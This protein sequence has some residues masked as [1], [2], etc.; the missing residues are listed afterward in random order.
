MQRT[1]DHKPEEVLA[2]GLQRIRGLGSFYRIALIVS[3]VLGVI[4]VIA[5]IVGPISSGWGERQP[6]TYVAVTFGFLMSTLGAAPCVSVG[7]RLVRSHWRRP[8][9]RLAEIWA[10]GMIVPLILFFLLLGLQP[11]TEGRNSVW[12]GWPASPW[13]WSSLLMVALVICGYAL[14]Y[15]AA[16]PD[17]AIL[18]DRAENGQ[19]TLFHRLAPNFRGTQRDWHMIEKGISYLGAFY[20]VLYTGTMSILASD[21]ILSFIPGHNSAIFPATYTIAGLESALAITIIAAYIARRWGGAAEYIDREQFFALGKMMLALGL[22]WFYTHWTEFVIWWYGRTPREIGLLKL[23]YFGPY[24]TLFCIAFALMFF[25]PLLVLMF[26]RIRMGIIG[27]TV[28]A[29]LVVIGQ[30]IDQV[31]LFSASFSNLDIYSPELTIIPHAY[32]PSVT[33]I[34]ILVG[35]TGGSLA[36]VLLSMKVVA[37]PSMWEVSAGLRLRVHRRFHKTEVVFIGKPE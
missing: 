15:L 17:M 29:V 8:I 11:G 25:A 3:A 32:L 14:L 5:L 1:W 7:T 4:G 27:P 10:A 19:R 2:D 22:L 35:L 6:W 34:L 12:F 28:V 21:W 13:L 23:L 9:N 20:V 18:R 36:L 30:A 31:R 33:D 16:I 24:F 26:T 37:L